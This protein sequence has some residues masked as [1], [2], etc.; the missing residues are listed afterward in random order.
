MIDKK[1]LLRTEVVFTPQVLTDNLIDRLPVNLGKLQ[2]LKLMN[3][4]G[5]RISSL[6]DECNSLL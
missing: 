1:I 3:L 4:D 5:N 6:P 2:S